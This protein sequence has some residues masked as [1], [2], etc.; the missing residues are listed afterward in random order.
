MVSSEGKR[1]LEVEYSLQRVREL[2]ARGNVVF[3]S[4]TVKRDAANLGYSHDD[5]C[6]CLQCLT[7]TN[8]DHSE[9]YS[10]RGPWHDIYLLPYRSAEGY[11]DPLYIKLK[12]NRD[13]VA[14][15]LC[16]FHRSR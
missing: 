14:V 3:A 6:A 10:D 1:R 7:P 9:Q 8:Y 4:S 13:C 16:S 2:A 11:I 12:L 15:L 5:V